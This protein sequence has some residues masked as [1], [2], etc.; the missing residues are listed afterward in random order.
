MLCTLK[1]VL[2]QKAI[3]VTSGIWNDSSVL[4]KKDHA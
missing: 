4:K 1:Y 3:C 2:N